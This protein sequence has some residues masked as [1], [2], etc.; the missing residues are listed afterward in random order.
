MFIYDLKDLVNH[1]SHIVYCH[2]ATL[3]LCLFVCFL[4]S[5]VT[6]Q[7]SPSSKLK[8]VS[9]MDLEKHVYVVPNPYDCIFC[10]MVF[11]Y[12]TYEIKPHRFG[13]TRVGINDDRFVIF[14]ELSL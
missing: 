9:H 10:N 1:I 2:I 4:S 6:I 13:M 11:L 8:R 12:L 7:H 3:K 14:S 5:F